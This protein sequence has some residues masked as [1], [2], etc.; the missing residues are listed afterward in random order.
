MS[1]LHQKNEELELLVEQRTQELKLSE[2]RYRTVIESVNDMIVITDPKG[3]VKF[4]NDLFMDEISTIAQTDLPF[5]DIKDKFIGNYFTVSGKISLEDV[6]QKI[7][8]GEE[9]NRLPMV[10]NSQ[11]IS[12]S[13]SYQS[14]VRGI[15]NE[16]LILQE[17]IFIIRKNL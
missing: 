13:P 17:I 5:K 12:T 3:D 1:E 6:Y 8:N 16:D 10:L 11:N 4:S 2:I 14:Y 15:F 9:I 7:S